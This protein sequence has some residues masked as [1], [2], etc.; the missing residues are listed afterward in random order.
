VVGGWC[1]EERATHSPETNG[2]RQERPV[3]QQHKGPPPK[4]TRAAGGCRREMPGEGMG[5]MGID[6]HGEVG[7][8]LED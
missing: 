1:L 3:C 7:K 6:A 5:K 8:K 2:A 4:S